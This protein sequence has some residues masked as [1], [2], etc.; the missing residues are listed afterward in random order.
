MN[1]TKIGIKEAVSLILTIAIAHVILSTPRR[2]LATMKSAVLL[3]LIYISILLILIVLLIVKLFKKFP[4]FDILDISEYLGGKN[5]KKVLGF[6]FIFYFVISSSVLLR[7]FSEALKVLYFPNTNVFFVML[8][9]VIAVGI[10]NKLEF[11]AA[12]RANLLSVP[13]VLIS[14]IFLFFSNTRLFNATRI[15]P[16]LGDGLFNTFILG[17]TNISSFAGI[18][19]IYFLPPL[20]KEPKA[21]KKVLISSVVVFFIFLLLNI[22]VLLFMF[23]HLMVENEIL[24][25]YTAFQYI[26]I[27]DFFVRFDVLFLL[28]WIEVLV[29]YLSI[30]QRF[31][32]LIMQKITSIKNQK[33]LCYPFCLL[34]LSVAMLPNTLGQLKIYEINVYPYISIGFSYIFCILILVFANL[35]KSKEKQVII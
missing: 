17:I 2:L 1:D 34:L 18:C 24:P 11:T 20:L 4:G 26:Q 12:I 13:L 27:G 10:I 21:F 15:F 19:F 7:E 3:N 32:M 31:T 22:A 28:V 5:F 6:F 29:F 14:C 16:I 8:L 9:F 35:K 23:S 25:L 30:V 33:I